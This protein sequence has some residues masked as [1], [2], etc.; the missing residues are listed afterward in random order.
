MQKVYVYKCSRCKKVIATPTCAGTVN[1]PHRTSK[2]MKTAATINQEAID[3]WGKVKRETNLSPET[4][5]VIDRFIEELR[6]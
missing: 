1:D 4:H 5:E 3:W 6:T 2:A